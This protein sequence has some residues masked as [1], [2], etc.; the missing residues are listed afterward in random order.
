[1]TTVGFIGEPGEDPY[2][3]LVAF[4]T[5]EQALSPYD[6]QRPFANVIHFDTVSL[7]SATALMDDLDW[8]LRRTVRE[9]VVRE[10]AISTDEWLSRELAVALRAERIE[11][12]DTAPFL[13]IYGI[14]DGSLVEPMYA[15]RLS[16]GSIPEYDLRR[17][18]GTF[19]IRVSDR[20]FGT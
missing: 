8:Y 4:E 19:P 7:G 9:A 20:A 14:D 17:V 2:E 12:A 13:K 3:A 5:A 10:P 11:P 16:D 6:V 1:M 15:E 18:E